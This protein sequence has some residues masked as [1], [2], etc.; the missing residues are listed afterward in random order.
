VAVPDTFGGARHF[1][2][3]HVC[4]GGVRHFWRCQTLSVDSP[5]GAR[6][7]AVSD[8]FG[9]QSFWCHSPF[10][11]RH[12]A[13]PDT[14]GE[15]LLWWRCQTLLAVPDTRGGARHFLVRHVCG[16]GA[17]HFARVP[18]TPA[19]VSDTPAGARHFRQSYGCQTLLRRCQTLCAGARHSAVS[20]SPARVSDTPAGVRHFAVP[21]S[22]A[23]VSDTLGCQ[24]V[25]R[26]CQTLCS[27]RHC[28][29][30]DS[31]A[32]VRHFWCQTVLRRCQT[33]CSARH[34]AV[35]DSCGCQTL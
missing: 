30:P 10:G 24:T 16:G 19:P 28:A 5:F 13:V 9:R 3:R 31:P 17:R 26:R 11:A 20:D 1:L 14:F 29:V 33:L 22:P 25:L 23:P 8:T 27:A 12:F 7:F 21:D 6:H 15:A 4:G 2:V 35:P 34:C 18:D 32:G